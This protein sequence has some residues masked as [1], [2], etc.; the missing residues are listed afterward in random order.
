MSD[1]SGWNY[2]IRVTFTVYA[3]TPDYHPQS[4]Q[5]LFD[6]YDAWQLDAGKIISVEYI[7]EREEG[8]GL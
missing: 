6:D 4:V 7:G 5:D 1:D 8:D 2:T 3:N